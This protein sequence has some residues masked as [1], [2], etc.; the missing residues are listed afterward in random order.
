MFC[1]SASKCAK[2]CTLFLWVKRHLCDSLETAL[3]AFGD[4]NLGHLGRHFQS[5]FPARANDLELGTL[6]AKKEAH[7][8]TSYA[9]DTA[10]SLT[11]KLDVS[12]CCAYRNFSVPAVHPRLCIE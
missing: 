1:V 9:K 5:L 8:G 11:R 3:N 2:F 4:A 12:S 10:A 7:T 6:T